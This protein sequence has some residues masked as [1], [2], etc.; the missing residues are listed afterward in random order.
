M[1]TQACDGRRQTGE[2]GLHG[3][4]QQTRAQLPSGDL[5][6]TLPLKGKLSASPDGPET[7]AGLQREPFNQ[8]DEI[9]PKLKA[10]LW[11]DSSFSPF[12]LVKV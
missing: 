11:F 8:D 12:L 1:C 10:A 7:E 5:I 3:A 9:S 2:E 6:D 4:A